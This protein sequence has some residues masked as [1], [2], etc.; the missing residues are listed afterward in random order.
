MNCVM[1]SVRNFNNQKKQCGPPRGR[2]SLS[3]ATVFCAG[4]AFAVSLCGPAVWA[5]DASADVP[6]QQQVANRV[7]QAANL[8]RVFA[9]AAARDMATFEVSKQQ[10]EKLVKQRSKEHEEISQALTDVKEAADK[11]R[12]EAKQARVAVEKSIAERERAAKA[13]DEALAQ[14]R[15]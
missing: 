3:L 8:A 7:G 9:D 11:A 6:N 10:I 12:E 2:V 14:S 4:I 13:F 15:K 1:Q 5:Q